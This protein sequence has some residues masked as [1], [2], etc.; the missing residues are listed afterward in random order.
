MAA[1]PKVQRMNTYQIRHVC[2]MFNSLLFSALWLSLQPA[3]SEATLQDDSE[4]KE[5]R[6]SPEAPLIQV[7]SWL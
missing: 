7:N 6:Y 3:P 4:P 2:M 1:K 5:D